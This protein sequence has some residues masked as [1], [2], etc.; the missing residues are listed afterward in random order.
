MSLHGQLDQDH[1]ALIHCAPHMP[2]HLLTQCSQSCTREGL[3]QTMTC[4]TATLCTASRGAQND[5]ARPWQSLQTNLPFCACT[6]P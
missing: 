4:A 2:A 1:S 3:G 6:L 5:A